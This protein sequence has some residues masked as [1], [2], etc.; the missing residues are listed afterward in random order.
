MV[1]KHTTL[2]RQH[3]YDFPDKQYVRAK[4]MLTGG[5]AVERSCGRCQSRAPSDQSCPAGAGESVGIDSRVSAG[6]NIR[7]V[8][9]PLDK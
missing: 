8:F 2:T 1:E 4:P 5:Y 7:D 9:L 3:A 6:E